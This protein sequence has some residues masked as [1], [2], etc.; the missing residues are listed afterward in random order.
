M[1]RIEPLAAKHWPAIPVIPL[2]QAGATDGM[3]TRSAGIP[4]Y[5]VSAVESNPDDV[6]AHGRDERIGIESFHKAAQFWL[7]LM[8]G[9]GDDTN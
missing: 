5:G 8:R 7:E 2:M 4:T 9:F 1:A 6:R 3:Y